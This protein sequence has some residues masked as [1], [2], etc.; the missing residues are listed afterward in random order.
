M[1]GRCGPRASRPSVP[2]VMGIVNVTPDSFSDGGRFLDPA[3]AVAHGRVRWRE[4][5]DV[6]DVGGESTRPGA[7][8]VSVRGGDP[9]VVPVIEGLAP[10]RCGSVDRH[11]QGRGGPRRGGRR[12][13]RS[14][15][16]CRPSCGRWP[17]SSAWAGWPCTCR[18]SRRPCRPTPGTRTWWP[19]CARSSPIGPPG[20][21][22]QG[23]PEIWVDPG[24]GFGKT[25]DTQPG[26]AGSP[27]R[28]V[29]LGWPVLVGTSRKGSLGRILAD[30]D[31]VRRSRSPR[32]IASPDRSP[33]RCGR[34]SAGA[35]MV[36]VH[37]VAAGIQAAKVVAA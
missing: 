10:S 13:P 16:T 33:P 36:R 25:L 34:C 12:A 24:F 7:D 18:A 17:P 9:R 8:P 11:P 20:R 21:P 27:R 22:T 31:A 26:P 30:S 2:L 14:S 4:G 37:D 19:R 35:S 23:S 1:S 3:A 29:D 28:V 32:P 15:T 6:V 5:A